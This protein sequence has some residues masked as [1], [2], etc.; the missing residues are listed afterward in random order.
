MLKIGM[1]VENRYKILRE[2]GR[3]GTSCVYLAENVRLHNFW[4][5]K[6]VYKSRLTAFGESSNMLI[7]ESGVLTRLRHSGLPTIVDIINTPQSYLLVMKY[8]EGVSLD[9][10]LAQKGACSQ[11]DVL[12]WAY[13]LCDVLEYL[14]SRTPA[15]IYRDM[16]PANIMLKPDGN[17]VLIDFGMAREF[18][19][20]SEQ[21]TTKL[22][23]HGYAA[24][25][26]YSGKGQTDARSDIYS[27]G[28]TLYHLVTG[29]DP[30]VPPYGLRPL[31]EINP[32]LSSRLER[33][34]TKC[35]QLEPNNRYQSVKELEN[36]LSGF[37]TDRTEFYDPDFDQ[38][39]KS[40]KIWLWF[41][42]LTLVLTIIIAIVVGVSGSDEDGL[43]NNTDIVSSGAEVTL[44]AGRE[45]VQDVTVKEP[46]TH[47]YY[48]IVPDTSGY[49]QFSSL[50]DDA[51]PVVWIKDENDTVLEKANTKG[52]YEDFEVE[53]WLK[54]GQTYYL[55]TTLY[56]KNRQIPST[57]SYTIYANYVGE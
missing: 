31:R 54:E 7:A 37:S 45:A 24:P 50:S 10:V 49:Y 23:T 36:A 40:N 38:A 35:T 5:I 1:S 26:Q 28:I 9:K 6:E 46:D 14:H 41:L 55:E 25:E 44:Y 29:H 53:C 20:R 30:C 33:V 42:I 52:D 22:G 39:P 48:K 43:E 19:V 18:K 47:I 13:Q 8:I 56:D 57:G 15:I 34:I 17:I 12:K 2:I 4:A 3:G 11:Q 27:L 21:D 32:S 16:K 51:R